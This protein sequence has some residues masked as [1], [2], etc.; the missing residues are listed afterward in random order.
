MWP[1]SI[2]LLG[3][4]LTLGPRLFQSIHAITRAVNARF[5]IASFL[6]YKNTTIIF[7]SRV[8]A[9]TRRL[10]PPK[11]SAI[12]PD[13]SSPF[14]VQL[15]DLISPYRSTISIFAPIRVV[16]RFIEVMGDTIDL[17]GDG[18]V[19]KTIVRRPKADATGPSEDLPL[20][21]VH[22]EGTLA[23]T[24]EVFD[25]THEDNTV[26]SFE[27]GKGSVIQAWDIALR[28]MKVG[29]VRKNHLQARICIW[30]CRISS[31]HPTQVLP[32]FPV[33]ESF[34]IDMHALN[35]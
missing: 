14:P 1:I 31:R 10:W 24:G 3:Q 2:I 5:L 28:T 25:T 16:K 30:K 15:A 27:V 11:P 33:I 34:L 29:E 12:F 21:D 35:G 23:E 7:H 32:F 22:Y 8:R 9:L 26:F 4:S 19:L 17:A 20:V 6:T 13:L 18:G